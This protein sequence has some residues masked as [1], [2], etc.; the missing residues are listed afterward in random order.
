MQLWESHG[1]TPNRYYDTCQHAKNKDRDEAEWAFLKAL[2]TRGVVTFGETC[3]LECRASERACTR[4]RRNDPTYLD[5]VP[6]DVVTLRKR[7]ERNGC[8]KSSTH[9]TT[10]SKVRHHHDYGSSV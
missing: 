2:H 5:L 9:H 10:T 8:K 7:A 3:V 6:N 4:C 1:A